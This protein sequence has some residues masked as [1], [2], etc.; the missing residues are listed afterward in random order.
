MSHSTV[1]VIGENPEEQLAPFDENLDVEPYK[2]HWNEDYLKR[3]LEHYELDDVSQVTEEQVRDWSG[4]TEFGIDDDGF[5]SMCSYNPDSKWDWYQLGGRWT[6]FFKMKPEVE[7]TGTVGRPG[8]MTD[9]AEDGRADQAYKEDID[10]EGMR[11]QAKGK[12]MEQYD[13]MLAATEGLDL[14]MSWEHCRDTYEPIE[15]AREVYHK[16]PFIKAIREADLESGWLGPDAT[17]YYFLGQEDG[18]EKFINRA[19]LNSLLTFAVLKDGEWFERG[20]MGWWGMVGDEQDDE[21]W[22]QQFY[23][24]LNNLSDDTLLSVYDVHI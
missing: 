12:A 24:L 3:F 1:L 5:Y 14:P 16:Q 7:A 21:E 23:D 15:V 4:S 13:R 6:G 9:P 19:V 20:R 22:S 18:R 10:F 11:M 2:D 17:N 8:I